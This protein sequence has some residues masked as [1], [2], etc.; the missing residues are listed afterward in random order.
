[1]ARPVSSDPLSILV[2]YDL[3][4]TRRILVLCSGL[5]REQFHQR[6]EIGPGSLHDTL[7]HVILCI[8]RWCERLAGR[9]P[10]PWALEKATERTVADLGGMLE[11]AHERLGTEIGRAFSLG[12]SS[13]ITMTYAGKAFTFTRGAVITHVLNHGTHHR[14]QCLNMLRRLAVTGLSDALPDI[15]VVDWQSETECLAGMTP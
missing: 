3:W 6:F 1:M 15:D 13:T 7:V 14:A 9:T 8:S 2:A 5:S 10:G 4:A 11:S 12:L